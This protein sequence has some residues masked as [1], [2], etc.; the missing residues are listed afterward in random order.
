MSDPLWRAD[1]PNR[2]HSRASRL[3]AAVSRL[4]E[5]SL[6]GRLEGARTQLSIDLSVAGA[7]DVARVLVA[8]LRR[9]PGEIYV[10]P[11]GAGRAPAAAELAEELR[12][13]AAAIDPQRPLVIGRTDKPTAAAHLGLNEQASL[14]VIAD[15]HGMRLVRQGGDLEQSRPPSGLGVVFAAAIAA[16]EI[17]K[18]SADVY[19]QL[20][21]DHERLAFCPVTLS[22]DL[23][24]A[25]LDLPGALDL[26]L[27]GLGAVGTATALILSGLDTSG[28]LVLI[29]DEPFAEENL[30]TYSLGG[31]EDAAAGIAKV[32]LAA[33][34]LGAFDCHPFRGRVEQAIKEIDDRKL[35][36]TQVVMSGLDS[37]EARHATQLL[38]PDLLID[39][40]TG[41]TAAGVR[42]CPD[43]GACLMCLVQ[44]SKREVSALTELIEL[45]GLSREDLTDGSRLLT[46]D[47][48]ERAK[49]AIRARMRAAVGAPVCGLGRAIGLAEGGEADYRPSIPFVSQQAACLGVGRL[50]AHLHA[51]AGSNHL[52]ANLV[53]YDTLL[54][55][56]QLT[57]LRLRPREHCYSVVR[58]PIIEQVREQRRSLAD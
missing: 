17:F 44:E 10:D 33:A 11:N 1:E 27:V 30:G 19:P 13:I 57:A 18:E 50:I 7:A 43:G 38:W 15:G 54:G 42:L 37:V 6:A 12:E 35:P 16:G 3:G 48:V 28:R 2:R 20:R 51:L 36:W 14:R 55:P 49:P 23:D 9:Q 5:S 40:S 56:T 8:T 34:K 21:I 29:D 41:D 24:R 32:N 26:T 4:N 52:D 45:T 25:P 58:R 46:D 22:D 31:A 47:D 39:S 53:Q